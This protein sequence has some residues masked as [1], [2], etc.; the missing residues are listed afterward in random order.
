MNKKIIFI[1]LSAGILGFAIA[2]TGNAGGKAKNDSTPGKDSDTAAAHVE[3]PKA[4]DRKYNDIARF[5]A[6]MPAETGSPF[7]KFDSVAAYKQFVT[8]FNSN[9]SKM[10]ETRMVKLRQWRDGEITPKINAKL[11]CFY[12]FSGPDFL[13]AYEFYPQASKYLMFAQESVGSLPDFNRLSDERKMAYMFALQKSMADIFNRSYYITQYMGRDLP[14]IDGTVSTFL[15]YLARTGHTIDNME[16]IGIDSLGN[17]YIR[18]GRHPR[19]N[20]VRFYFHTKENVQKTLEYFST[21]ISNITEKTAFSGLEKNPGVVTYIK[22]YG[23]SNTFIKAAS[24]LLHY[25]TFSMIRNSTIGISESILEDD[26]GIPYRFLK[27]DFELYPYG[28]YTYPIANF[29]RNLY[30]PNDLAKI[31][32]DS[33]R[34]KPLPISLGYHVKD[35]IQNYMLYVR[36]KK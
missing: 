3:A 36:K 10:E 2:C 17:S 33:N 34:V 15:V 6:G 11:P 29:A 35:G 31:Y 1:I 12:P 7:A 27:N 13:H 32:A 22:K 9:W 5:L 25:E 26:P 30:Q 21:D 19:V 23:K 24:Y 18:T 28:R 14:V 8:E 20:G 16:Y 4:K